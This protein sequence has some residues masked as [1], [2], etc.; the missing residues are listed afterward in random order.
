MRLLISKAQRKT[1]RSVS[2]QRQS[3]LTDK[4]ASLEDLRQDNLRLEEELAAARMREAEARRE[5]RPGTMGERQ[6]AWERERGEAELMRALEERER[7]MDHAPEPAGEVSVAV[8]RR[9]S[10]SLRRR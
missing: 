1:P 2:R 3:E 6:R 5:R 8:G 4:L 9:R 7:L 10:P